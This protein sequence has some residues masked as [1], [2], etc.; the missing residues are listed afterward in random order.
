[1]KILFVAHSGKISGGANRSLLSLMTRLRDDYGH[2]PSVLIPA[3]SNELMHVCEQLRIPTYTAKYRSCCT[4]FQRDAKDILRFGKI[5][6]APAMQYVQAIRMKRNLPQDFDLVYTNERIVAVGA[7]LAKRMK[8]PHVW[9]VRTF[10][11]ELKVVY[12]PYWYRLMKQYSTRIVLISFALYRNFSQYIPEK[13]LVMIHNGVDIASFS[14]KKKHEL[15]GSKLLLCGRIVPLKG[16]IEA[17]RALALLKEKKIDADLYLAGDIPLYSDD[18]YYKNL[19][20]EAEAAGVGNSIHFLGHVEDM[21]AL[22]EEMDAELVCT[23]CEAFG[24]VTVEAMTA[25]LPVIGTDAGGTPEIIEDGVT[26]F[27]YP[28]GN[29]QMLAEKIEWLLLHPQ[30]A[31]QMGQ[32]GRMRAAAHFSIERTVECIHKLVTELA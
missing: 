12:P 19:C 17:V 20:K 27:L 5:L 3:D 6:L 32:R 10:S 16:Q 30:E 15:P 9:H 2:E 8:L 23:W 14:G 18:T 28:S 24:R 22:R 29:V 1:M 31:A 21:A 7:F 25:A 26:G 11:D 13:Q 4:T